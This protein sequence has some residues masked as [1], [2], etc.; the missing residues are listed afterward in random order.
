[1]RHLPPGM[2][3]PCRPVVPTTGGCGFTDDLST[4]V[5]METH[6]PSLEMRT[7]LSNVG[8]EAATCGVS[9]PG[10]GGPAS[11]GAPLR[12][13]GLLP[14][15]L[16][17]LGLAHLAWPLPEARARP[18]LGRRQRVHAQ[19]LVGLP[20]CQHAQGVLWADS[21][22]DPPAT[23]PLAGPMAVVGS[24]GVLSSMPPF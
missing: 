5:S 20:E 21:R 10:R 12:P 7:R 15:A 1:M 6:R 19:E 14:R 9:G 8:D 17:H 2:C 23:A 13:T 3:V 18:A 4:G 16:A 11:H 24:P 22:Q